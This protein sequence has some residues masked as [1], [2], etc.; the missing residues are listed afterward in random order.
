MLAR[1][2]HIYT[3]REAA[4]LPGG[5]IDAWLAPL[6]RLLP[7]AAIACVALVLLQ[8]V[9]ARP[10]FSFVLK[11]EQAMTSKE[12]LH[13]ERAVYR[14]A[15][16]QGRPFSVRA[17]DAVQ[18][19]SAVPMVE[20]RRIDAEMRLA[21]GPARVTAG[22]GV[23]D[24]E[25]DRLSLAGPVNAVQGGYGLTTGRATLDIPSQHV[26]SDGPVTGHSA[27]GRFSAARM[28]ADVAGQS[29]VLSGGARLHIDRRVGR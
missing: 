11:R 24:I 28:E 14:G 18:R 3:P 9:S 21:S 25:H 7:W 4:A 2:P 6:K 20:M 12:R 23:Y 27:L 26:V 19:S 5:P 22:S 1:T 8:I 16:K 29:V 13:V 15:D 17:D 10:E